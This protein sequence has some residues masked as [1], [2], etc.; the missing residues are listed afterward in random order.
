MR[1]AVLV[2]F[3]LATALVLAGKAPGAWACSCDPLPD[4][5]LVRHAEIVF[6]GT[7]S[8]AEILAADT[9]FGERVRWTFD[10]E[11]VQK[12]RVGARQTV[13]GSTNE[14]A[15]G[16]EF[17]EGTRYRVFASTNFDGDYGVEYCSGTHVLGNLAVTSI[18][19]AGLAGA[20]LTMIMGGV[21]LRAR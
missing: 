17:H 5:E 16:F 20:A 14:G 8:S 6:I 19:L 4:E 11:R 13:V 9:G 12:G 10:V 21:F 7:V 2:A 1:R 18:P 3:L 15:C